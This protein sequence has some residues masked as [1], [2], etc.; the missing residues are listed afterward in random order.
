MVS[1]FWWFQFFVGE[2]LPMGTCTYLSSIQD[3]GS[4]FVFCGSGSGCFSQCW[5]L[6]G[7]SFKKL[8]CD[9]NSYKNT[10]EEFIVIDLI[11]IWQVLFELKEG[12]YLQNFQKIPYSFLRSLW[13]FKNENFAARAAEL[14]DIFYFQTLQKVLNH[15]TLLSTLIMTAVKSRTCTFFT[16]NDTNVQTVCWW[17]GGG[18]VCEY[19]CWGVNAHLLAHKS[20]FLSQTFFDLKFIDPIEYQGA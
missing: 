17:I 13:V 11:R 1:H 10:F 3:C 15:S 19:K 2:K 18:G 7:S 9:F 8:R 6:S 4:V 12:M 14:T 5:S 16:H 20:L